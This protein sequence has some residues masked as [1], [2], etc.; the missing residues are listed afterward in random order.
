MFL[1]MW[2][3][4]SSMTKTEWN[5]QI[6]LPCRTMLVHCRHQQSKTMSDNACTLQTSALAIKDNVRQCL[7]TADISIGNQ[8]QCRTMLVH[9]RHQQS[10]TMSDNACTLQT[11]A[12]KDNV[13]Q[14]LHTADISNQRQCQTMLVHCRHQHRQSETMSDNACTLQTSALAIK[15]DGTKQNIS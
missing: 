15:D 2:L 5:L 3:C 13:R 6:Q 4:W 8:R 1:V 14:C 9:C 10:K 12:I 7:Y 11:S